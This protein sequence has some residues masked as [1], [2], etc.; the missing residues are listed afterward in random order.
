MM[1]KFKIFLINDKP[2]LTIDEDV[3][4]GDHAVVSVNELYPTLV[5]CKNEEQIKIIQQPVTS[6]TKR[7]KVVMMP[8]AMNLDD[9]F[10]SVLKQKEGAISVTMNN[11]EIKIV[12]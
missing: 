8:D 1:D 12:D 6:M 4:I 3:K 7:H 2:Y 10:L 9:T 5:E 11:G